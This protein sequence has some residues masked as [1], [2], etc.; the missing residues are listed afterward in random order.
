MPSEATMRKRAGWP[1]T[2]PETNGLAVRLTRDIRGYNHTL[3]KGLTGRIQGSASRWD[4]L[5]F[6][7]DT[8]ATCGVKQRQRAGWQSFEVIPLEAT[9]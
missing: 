1:A 4:R 8:C 6:I 2:L 7:G 9:Q 5:D 3:P